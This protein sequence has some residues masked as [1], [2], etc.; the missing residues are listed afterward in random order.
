MLSYIF[1]N[2][3]MCVPAYVHSH[4]HNDK[5][6]LLLQAMCVGGGGAHFEFLGIWDNLYLMHLNL[7]IPEHSSSTRG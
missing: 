3:N 6:Y 4:I 5:V 1:I 2:F 7:C